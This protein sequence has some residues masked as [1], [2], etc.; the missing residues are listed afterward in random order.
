MEGFL[1]GQGWKF[2]LLQVTA[3]RVPKP[4]KEEGSWFETTP[5][6]QAYVF[7]DF[8]LLWIKLLL[9]S[10]LSYFLETC[11]VSCFGR[12]AYLPEFRTEKAYFS[13]L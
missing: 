3:P 1:H 8:N 9:S 13:V 2:V 12:L 7:L 4:W 10:D 6:F 5:A 11:C